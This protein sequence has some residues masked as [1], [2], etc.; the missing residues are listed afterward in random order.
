MTST[1]TNWTVTTIGGA[2]ANCYTV[3]GVGTNGH[4]NSPF[5]MTVDNAGALYIT[6][7]ES[8]RVGQ[9]LILQLTISGAQ[10]VVSWPAIATNFLLEGSSSLGPSAGWLPLTN[11]LVTSGARCFR[12]NDLGTAENFYRLRKQ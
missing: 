11:G 7:N 8:I 4:F 9:P 10:A 6:D 2:V 12:T 5:H 3:D 1:G